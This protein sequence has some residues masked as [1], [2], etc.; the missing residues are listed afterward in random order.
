MPDRLQLL[1][2]AMEK[3]DILANNVV[4][5]VMNLVSSEEIYLLLPIVNDIDMLAAN[6]ISHITL[7]R[8]A[9]H[10]ESLN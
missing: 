9:I 2:E 3:P 10:F 5:N 7:V 4:R 1:Y 6:I 8:L